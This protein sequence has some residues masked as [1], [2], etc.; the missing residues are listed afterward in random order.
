[1]SKQ[2]GHLVITPLA[3]PQLA[4]CASSGRAWR[5]WAARYSQSETQPLGAPPP[6]QLLERAASEGLSSLARPACLAEK[7]LLSVFAAIPAL[8]HRTT[9]RLWAG[10]GARDRSSPRHPC[11][12]GSLRACPE[13]SPGAFGVVRNHMQAAASQGVFLRAVR[14][15]RCL[16]RGGIRSS[17]ARQRVVEGEGGRGGERHGRQQRGGDR[18]PREGLELHTGCRALVRIVRARPSPRLAENSG[19]KRRDAAGLK[20][21]TRSTQH[22][23]KASSQGVA[24]AA[25]PRT[26]Q[27]LRLIVGIL[28]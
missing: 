5:L 7:V 4:P 13:G 2:R 28:R 23:R 6:P 19:L 26:A 17:S 27:A 18:A 24:S 21:N 10:T 1:M 22:I 3:V 9:P 20:H 8:V 16:L 12:E 14:R 25:P 11:G 15:P